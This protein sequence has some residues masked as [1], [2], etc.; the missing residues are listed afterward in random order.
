MIKTSLVKE[1]DRSPNI[2]LVYAELILDFL[3]KK[4]SDTDDVATPIS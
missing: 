1:I 4:A 2:H 3:A